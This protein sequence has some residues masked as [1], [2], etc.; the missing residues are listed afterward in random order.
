MWDDTKQARLDALREKE[1]QATLTADEDHELTRLYAELDADEAER[2][3]SAI[4][5][6]DQEA[7]ELEQRNPQLAVLV[8]K[9]RRL[10]ARMRPEIAEWVDEYEELKKDEALLVGTR[11][12]G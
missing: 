2:L 10:L 6:M 9:N 7:A 1:E 3:H 5:R 4:E 8:E 12:A 11:E